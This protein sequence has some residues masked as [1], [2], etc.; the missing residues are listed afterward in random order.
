MPLEGTFITLM[1]LCSTL[2]Q[3]ERECSDVNSPRL[4]SD[5]PCTIYTSHLPHMLFFLIF[6][7]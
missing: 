7:P 3:V 5:C 4:S 6:S 1:A 2:M